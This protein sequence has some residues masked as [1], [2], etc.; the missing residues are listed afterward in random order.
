MCA[1]CGWLFLPPRRLLLDRRTNLPRSKYSPRGR[2]RGGGGGEVNSTMG[3]KNVKMSP[4]VCFTR[5]NLSIWCKG[6]STPSPAPALTD[7]PPPP[8]EAA[9][10]ATGYRVCTEV[11]TYCP[12]FVKFSLNELTAAYW[13]RRRRKSRPKVPVQITTLN[14]I[15]RGGVTLTCWGGREGHLN[16]GRHMWKECPRNP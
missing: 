8:S 9:A 5:Y 2:G 15:R 12:A 7:S 13:R 1:T 16:R 14:N 11:E 3:Q 6:S 4:S 10:A